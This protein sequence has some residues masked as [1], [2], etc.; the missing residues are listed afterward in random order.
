MRSINNTQQITKAMEMVAAAKLR[1]AQEKALAARPYARE[2]EAM[3]RRVL[4]AVDAV[5]HPLLMPREKH[6]AGYVVLTSD[7]GLCGGFNGQVLRKAQVLM[8]QQ[9]EPAVI[10]VGRRGRDYFRRRGYRLSAE[11]IAVGDEPTVGQTREIAQAL[12]KLYE[13][14]LIDEINLV[15]NEFISTGTHRPAVARLLP[16][17]TATVQEAG[18]ELLQDYFFEPDPE[19]VLDMLLPR[20]IIGKI[21]SALLESKASEQAARMI[22]MGAASENALEMI[23]QLTL[24]FNKARQAAITK[25]LSEIV[26]GVAALQ[27]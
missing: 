11:F 24:S 27:G 14:N 23:N 18:Q 22:A 3:I 13:K 19:A 6:C 26:G 10:A 15:Y 16:L 9:N 20:F 12:F 7:R 1:H 4:P 17:E 25:E 8:A 2:I 21:Y 5:N